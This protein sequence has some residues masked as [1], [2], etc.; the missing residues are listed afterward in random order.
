MRSHPS[1]EKLLRLLRVLCCI[2]D[3][4]RAAG[5]WRALGRYLRAAGQGGWRAAYGALIGFEAIGGRHRERRYRR[6]LRGVEPADPAKVPDLAFAV[7]FAGLDRTRFDTFLSVLADLGGCAAF[8]DASA[9]C[10]DDGIA[11]LRR[12]GWP[13]AATTGDLDTRSLPDHCKGVVFLRAGHCPNPTC[14]PKIARAI[15]AGAELVYGDAD[16]RGPAGRRNPRFKPDFSKDLLLYRDYISDCVGVSKDALA[17]LP[18]WDFNDPHASVL[19]W[20]D[21]LRHIRHLPHVLSHGLL[22]EERRRPMPR[23]L[24]HLLRERYGGT[25]EP[26]SNGWR[27]RYPVPDAMRIAVVVPTRDRADLLKACIGTLYERNRGT[28]FETVVV[29]NR[30]SDDD[31]LA[32]LRNAPTAHPGLSVVAADMAF[33][34]SRLNN[35]ALAQADADVYVFLNNDTESTEDGWLRRLAEYALRPDVGAVG[36]LLVYG[37]GNIQH[38]GIVAGAGQQADLVYRGTTP[39]FADHAFVSP[40]LPR[41]VSA[42]TGACLAVSAATLQ[43]IGPFDERLAVAGDV[44]F[45][46]RARRAG[47]ANVYAGDVALVHRES[48]TRRRSRYP[49]DE[50]RLRALIEEDLPQD[51]YYNPN[52]AQV[53]GIG[54]G[55]PA[56]AL[57]HRE[58][59]GLGSA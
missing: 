20:T 52:L 23:T 15:E 58:P 21:Q 19:V 3:A 59:T 43:A 27:C 9:P 32:W 38:A 56:Y 28:A 30:S 37:D 54:R 41:N 24:P 2:G 12:A 33:N 16:E 22:P 6:W 7:T 8:V 46:L 45:C 47:L 26:T 17:R 53:P 10:A 50:A 55:A 18:G 48:L 29:D 42:V 34:W 35:I 25:V 11:A 44:E 57:L 5:G 14:V 49:E 1:T 51:P 13:A 39:D 36:P 31:A 40:R 4:V